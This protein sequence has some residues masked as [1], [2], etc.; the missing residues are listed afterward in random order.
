MMKQMVKALALMFVIFTVSACSGPILANPP[1]VACAPIVKTTPTPPRHD[2]Q[3]VQFPRDHAPTDP[4]PQL[5][6]VTRHLH[7][8]DGESAV[9]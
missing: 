4:P 5:G 3:P 7:T 1:A 6:N 9:W 2:P 8:L